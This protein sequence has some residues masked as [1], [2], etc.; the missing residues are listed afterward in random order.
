MIKYISSF[1]IYP[2]MNSWNRK[3]GYSFNVKIYNL[4]L[5]DEE[6]NKLYEIIGDENLSECFYT[7]IYDLIEVWRYANIKLFGVHR[8]ENI[9]N[10]EYPNFTA[11]LN[12][13]SSGHLVLGKWN[14]YNYCGSGW[15]FTEEELKDMSKEDVRYIYKVLR[16]FEKLYKSIIKLCRY[17]ANRK[18]EEKTIEEVKTIKYKTFTD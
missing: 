8:D 12:G 18:I 13:R 16:E 9:K 3:Y 14:G 17:Y 4:P 11:F 1:E 15:C 10:I 6:K 2:T 5:K 7:D